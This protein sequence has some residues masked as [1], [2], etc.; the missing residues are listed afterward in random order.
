MIDSSKIREHMEVVGSD[1]EHV[2]TVDHCEG[3]DI[4]KLT[5]NDPAAN[6]EHHYIPMAWVNRIDQRV[7]LAHPASEARLHWG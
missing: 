2:G 3:A 5:K 7:H 1:G 4:I 6:G